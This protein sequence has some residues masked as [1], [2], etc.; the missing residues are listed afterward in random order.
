MEYRKLGNTDL[1]VSN[2]SFGA[3]SLGGVFH[4]VDESKAIQSVH[5]VIEQGIN[6]I[7]VSP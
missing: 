1:K 6:F 5:T 2:I 4:P 7:D 3:S